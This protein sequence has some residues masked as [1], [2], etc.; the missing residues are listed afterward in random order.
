MQTFKHFVA[1]NVRF[2]ENYSVCMDKRKRVEEV[3]TRKGVIFCERLLMTA[4]NDSYQRIQIFVLPP[5]ALPA[6][7]DGT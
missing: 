2:F 4:S 6:R 5:L 7:Y 3:R 1:K